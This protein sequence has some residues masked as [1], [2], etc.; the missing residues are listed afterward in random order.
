MKVMIFVA[1]L[2]AAIPGYAEQYTCSYLGYLSNEP[3]VVKINIEGSKAHDGTSE[4]G[5]LQ[6][7]DVGIVL[8]RSFANLNSNREKEIGLFGFVI[9]KPS[10]K[11]TRGN[12]IR[13]ESQNAIRHG[14][15]VK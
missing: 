3:V 1:L 4:Y 8:V 2:F 7:N 5:V 14:T 15:C 13:G 10:L 9:E 12:I 11:M 6:N